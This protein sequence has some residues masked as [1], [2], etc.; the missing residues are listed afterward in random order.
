MKI[1]VV[2]GSPGNEGYGAFTNRY[3]IDAIKTDKD[4]I[5]YFQLNTI[6]F[7]GCQACMECKRKYKICFLNDS[8]TDVLESIR[9][10]D[11]VLLSAPVYIGD[12]NAQAKALVDRMYSFL[13]DDYR[14]NPECGRL[15]A[16]KTL[17]FT[18]TQG[19]QNEFTYNE[20]KNRYSAFFKR[21]GFTTVFT[22]IVIVGSSEKGIIS[23]ESVQKSIK[24]IVSQLQKSK[25]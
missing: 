12:I 4:T 14:T 23:S 2:Q 18:L 10:S 11:L 9:T 16:G 3:L 25:N 20:V 19:N 13:T 8:L 24:E 15:T 5:D 7:N 21:I 1:S 6:S 17:I 22:L